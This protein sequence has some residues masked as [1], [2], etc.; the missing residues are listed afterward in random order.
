MF[1]IRTLKNTPMQYT[2]NLNGCKNDNFQLNFELFSYFC[3]K[4]RSWVHV[5]TA[6]NGLCL[7]AEAVLLS[8]HDL[9]FRAKIRKKCIPCKP[10]L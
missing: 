5:R 3:S 4:H 9:C 6:N 10:A 2:A 1:R 7:R 8:T